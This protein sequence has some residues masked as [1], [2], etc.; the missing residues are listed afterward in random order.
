M[1]SAVLR[2]DLDGATRQKEASRLIS[3]T[4]PLPLWGRIDSD[5][6]RASSLIARQLAE[7]LA[8]TIKTRRAPFQ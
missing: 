1:S 8:E 2:A 4:L 7:R 3:F 5:H 6:A